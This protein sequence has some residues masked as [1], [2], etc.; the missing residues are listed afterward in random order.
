[1]RIPSD[2]IVIQ[3]LFSQKCKRDIWKY[4][5]W[6]V[7]MHYLCLRNVYE[8]NE[9]QS[10]TCQ[11]LSINLHIR[12]LVDTIKNNKR[13]RLCL[14][15]WL[16]LDVLLTVYPTCW[17]IRKLIFNSSNYFN[18]DRREKSKYFFSR[19]KTLRRKIKCN[20]NLGQDKW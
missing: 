19:T 1:M 7:K 18:K 20:I 9:Y 8:W 5:S 17:H 6:W 4:N 3:N 12:R 10:N 11:L 14:H 15:S 16:S 13:S 2:I